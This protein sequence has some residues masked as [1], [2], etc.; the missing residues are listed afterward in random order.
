[1]GRLRA[2]NR[3]IACENITGE[4]IDPFEGVV[5]S[6]AAQEPFVH[7]CEAALSTLLPLLLQP[8]CHSTAPRGEV[9]EVIVRCLRKYS[10]STDN[11]QRW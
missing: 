1:M 2:L 11:E 7:P 3:T 6:H 9:F 8:T 10:M 4:H 5:V